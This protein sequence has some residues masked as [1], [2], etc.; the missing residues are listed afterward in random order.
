MADLGVARENARLE[1]AAGV[2]ERFLANIE[3]VVHGKRD[4][5]QARPRRAR[6][7]AA[8]CSS[9]TC[10]GRRRPCS[11][12]RSRRRVEGA[13]PSRIQCTPDLQP[14]DVTGLSVYD[15]RE[16]RVRVPPGPDLRQR[17]ARRRDQPGDAEDAV[18]A[19]RG[20]GRAAGDRRRGDAPAADRRS[21]CSRP[22]TRSSTRA[23][24]RCP[25]RSST[26]SSSRRRSA[27]RGVDDELRIIERPARRAPP[28]R[29]LEPV[30]S[31]DEVADA[32]GR[33]R[34]RLHRRTRWHAGSS[35]S[36]APRASSTTVAIGA[37][38]RGSLALER[39]VRAWALLD[40][41]RLRHAGRRRPAVPAGPRA[42]RSSS[43]PPCWRKR[44]SSAGRRRS[45]CSAASACALAPPPELVWDDGDGGA[46]PA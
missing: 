11:R 42:P 20:D 16:P 39:A 1:R 43:R 15:Q 41:R 19:A 32:P 28:L 26:A 40:G 33:G 6:V 18:G 12:A 30:V 23:P 2:A 9:R 35:T 38:V 27:T 34:G 8:T 14:T 36:C 13:T 31:V 44:A 25:R 22:R 5:D 29:D 3:T 46:R 21:C 4:R 17:R 45:S 37:S 24:S 7:R 10:P